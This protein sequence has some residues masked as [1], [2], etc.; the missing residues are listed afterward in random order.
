MNRD[1]AIIDFNG[2]FSTEAACIAHLEKARWPSKPACPYCKGSRS[3]AVPIEERHH[4]NACNVGFS[5]TVRTIFHHTHLP[6]RTWFL[7]AF[8]VLS[9]KNSAKSSCAVLPA[10]ASSR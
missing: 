4:C 9:A 2:T 8:L 5:V 3:T 7:A 10:S 6:L 1:L